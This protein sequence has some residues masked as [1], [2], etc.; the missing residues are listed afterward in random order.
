MNTKRIAAFLTIS[1][2][3][4]SMWLAQQQLPDPS[5]QL[6]FTAIV[7]AVGATALAVIAASFRFPVPKKKN[8]QKARFS[9]SCS[10]P[11]HIC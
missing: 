5:T 3:W 2:I 9:A 8:G 4:G 1:L 7:M 10:S 6:R 11:C